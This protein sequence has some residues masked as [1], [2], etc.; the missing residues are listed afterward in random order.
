[1]TIARNIVLDDVKSQR[2]RL[3]VAAEVIERAG[4][5][6]GPEDVV[7]SSLTTERLMRAMD[8]LGADQREC[9]M[10]RFIHGMSIGETAGITGRNR[11]A[12]KALQH[13]AIR[14][15][16]DLE[17]AGPLAHP[18]RESYGRPASINGEIDLSIESISNFRPVDGS[19]RK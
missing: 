1:M 7:I 17:A 16:A 10:L 14:R 18:R 6:P 15:L 13:R 5:G 4:G 9:V 12:V 19:P 2:R 8:R 3:E 11:G